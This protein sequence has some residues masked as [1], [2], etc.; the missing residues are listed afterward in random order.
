MKV[1]QIRLVVDFLEDEK[2]VFEL[3]IVPEND[4]DQ[5]K[6]KELAKQKVGRMLTDEI[7]KVMHLMIKIEV[8][9]FK[10]R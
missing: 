4:A 9:A 8:W 6:I 2:K 1:S 7:G 10:A 3:F 5:N